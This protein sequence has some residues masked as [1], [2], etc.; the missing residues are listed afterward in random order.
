MH[1]GFLYHNVHSVEKAYVASHFLLDIFGH[2]THTH[3]HTHT[4]VCVCVCVCMYVCIFGTHGCAFMICICEYF[5]D[6]VN[7]MPR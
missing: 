2:A 7:A 6:D 5:Y 4:Y 3:T 1:L